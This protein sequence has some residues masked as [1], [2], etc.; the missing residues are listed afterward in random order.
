M[1]APAFWDCDTTPTLDLELTQLF[2]KEDDDDEIREGRGRGQIATSITSDLTSSISSAVSRSTP[3][4]DNEYL[5]LEKR[6]VTSK[7]LQDNKE[8]ETSCYYSGDESEPCLLT[9]TQKR[10]ENLLNINH[11]DE[12]SFVDD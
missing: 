5:D 10:N 2:P 11:V 9:P 3:V 8:L 4:G 12:I 7:L 1:F 6:S